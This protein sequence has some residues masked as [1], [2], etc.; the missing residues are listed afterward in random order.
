VLPNRIGARED[1]LTFFNA[2][3]G[4]DVSFATK[5]VQQQQLAFKRRH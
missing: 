2:G 5:L 3:M 4:S 1:L